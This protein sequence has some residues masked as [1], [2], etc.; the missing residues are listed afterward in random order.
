MAEKKNT[1]I[2]KRIGDVT[3]DL[4]KHPVKLIPTIVLTVIWTVFA[5]ISAVGA[6][7]PF[8]R[9]LY[10]L[11]YANGGMFG[12]FFGFLGGVFGKA[13]YAALIS[14]IV[15]SYARKKNPF[16]GCATTVKSIFTGGY[17]SIEFACLGGGIGMILYWFFNITSAPVNIIISPVG[18]L[19]A[20]VSANRR[21]G[22]VYG[23][24]KAFIK[25]KDKADGI[26]PKLVSCFAAGFVIGFPLTFI[27]SGLVLFLT[28]LAM[29][30]AF[31]VLAIVKSSKKKA[32]V[33][34]ALIVLLVVPFA[35]GPVVALAAPDPGKITLVSDP[36][37]DVEFMAKGGVR[38]NDWDEWIYR[39][40]RNAGTI[41]V[42]KE[43]AGYGFTTPAWRYAWN[44]VSNSAV[45]HWLDIPAIHFIFGEIQYD[46]EDE[47]YF[48]VITAD[49][50]TPIEVYVHGYQSNGQ[51]CTRNH[52]LKAFSMTLRFAEKYKKY[53][54]NYYASAID[55]HIEHEWNTS[56]DASQVKKKDGLTSYIGS[57]HG[58]DIDGFQD[59][60]SQSQTADTSS[61]ASETTKENA[62]SSSGGKKTYVEED[63]IEFSGRLSYKN[64]NTNEHGQ[65]IPDLKDYDGDGVI[66]STDFY[67]QYR[68]TSDPDYLDRPQSELVSILAAVAV[69]TVGALAGGIGGALGGAAGA[70]A[71]TAAAAASASASA[72]TAEM[73]SGVA[74]GTAETSAETPRTE[75][76]YSGKDEDVQ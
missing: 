8:L 36:Y 38:S 74:S 55:S 66:G 49:I 11:T 59:G 51:E 42:E 32:A 12:G 18:A 71:A 58:F 62:P 44:D 63:P 4:F 30:I 13:V 61:A 53:M 16:K 72:A 31:V 47:S 76:N 41:N 23:F 68:L 70:S 33:A 26:I 35:L 64:G 7:A 9:F 6:N 19:L 75:E 29:I 27:R 10:T 50:K 17:E 65:K 39:T 2:F 69:G 37:Y 28:G 52:R 22:F 56:I 40:L 48:A 57:M 46:A 5:I 73:A 34:A 67:A 14:V 15:F 20:I 60:A 54:G 43:N 21:D 25:D 1:S 3:V 45:Q 24:I